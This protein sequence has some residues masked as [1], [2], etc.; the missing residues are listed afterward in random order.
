MT[1]L[2]G[3]PKDTLLAPRLIFTPNSWRTSSIVCKVM[4]AA[5]L[6]APT[7]STRGSMITSSAGIPNLAARSED[8][9][10]HFKAAFGGF[11]DTI[12]IHGQADYGCAELF[13][14]R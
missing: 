3:I 8:Y 5:L 1:C 13:D 2:S 6:L 10:S 7:V 14:Y 4:A 12:V 9:P 11:R